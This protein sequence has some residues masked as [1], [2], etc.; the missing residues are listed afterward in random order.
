MIIRR[1]RHKRKK[2]ERDY[3]NRFDKKQNPRTN[4]VSAKVYNK[5]I[6]KFPCEG[7]KG[8]LKYHETSYVFVVKYF[9]GVY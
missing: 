9:C 8:L 1:R 7:P 5:L 4:L 2:K 3:Q 6:A